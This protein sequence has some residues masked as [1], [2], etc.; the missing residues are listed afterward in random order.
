[1]LEAH[2]DTTPREVNT[3]CTIPA[4]AKLCKERDTPR[5]EPLACFGPLSSSLS[6]AAGRLSR[7]LHR[8]PP[9]P[10]YRDPARLPFPSNSLSQSQKPRTVPRH[11]RQC[12][13]HRVGRRLHTGLNPVST[14]FQPHFSPISTPFQPH[15]NPISTP[16]ESHSNPIKISF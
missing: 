13:L 12:G 16:F 1:M 5:E 14:P 15:F 9:L 11:S 4:M 10:P 2:Q 6:G 3:C 8:N 7:A